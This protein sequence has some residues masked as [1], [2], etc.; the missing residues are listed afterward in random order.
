[1]SNPLLSELRMTRQL[2]A[3]TIARI[4]LDVPEASS[5][6]TGAGGNRFRTAALARWN[7]A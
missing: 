6:V 7:R 4:D 1:M 3:Q 2:L 5:G